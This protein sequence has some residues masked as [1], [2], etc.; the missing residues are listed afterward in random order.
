[1]MAPFFNT[2]AVKI[3][4]VLEGD[5]YA[6]IIC[7]HLAKEQRRMKEEQWQSK[8]K[9]EEERWKTE[10]KGRYQKVS[11]RLSTGTV[12]V[13][14]PG[15]PAV[16]VAGREGLQAICFEVQAEN[17]QKMF[18]AGKNNILNEMEAEAKE[19]AFG[20]PARVVDEILQAQRDEVFLAGP[21]ERR[22]ERTRDD[23]GR[24]GRPLESILEFPAGF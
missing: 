8:Q 4:F 10:G 20:V 23:G 9:R 3:A 1:M 5:G 14:P 22:H 11:S 18:V 7:P 13:V 21:E 16:V 19:L 6:E 15:H 24:S 12:S 17:N 2:R